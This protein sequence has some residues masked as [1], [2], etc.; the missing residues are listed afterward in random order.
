V[1][2]KRRIK[3]MKPSNLSS[4]PIFYPYNFKYLTLDVLKK[5]ESQGEIKFTAID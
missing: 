5:Y 2:A 3:N 4:F 1:L